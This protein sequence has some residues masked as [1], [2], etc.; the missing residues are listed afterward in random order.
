MQKIVADYNPSTGR[1]EMDSGWLVSK[2]ALSLAGLHYNAKSKLWTTPFNWVTARRIRS[3]FGE[4]LEVTERL[5]DKAS[6]DYAEWIY[7]SLQA[8]T[9][10]STDPKLPATLF[11]YQKRGGSFLL[12]AKRAVLADA[13]RVGKCGSVI[14]AAELGDLYPMIWIGPKST[15]ISAERQFKAHVPHRTTKQLDGT[16][17]K[18]RK[19]LEK[20]VDVLFMSYEVAVSHSRLASYGSVRMKRCPDCGGVAGGDDEITAAKCQ[21]HSK[22]LNAIHFRLTVVDEAHNLADPKSIRTRGCWAI[23]D[24]TEYAFGLTGTPLTNHIGTYWSILRLVAQH[25]WPSKTR[26]IDN[27][28][29]TSVSPWGGMEIHGLNPHTIEEFYGLIEPRMW[30]RTYEDVHG[31]AD[32]PEPQQRFLELPTAVRKAYNQ[33]DDTWISEDEGYVTTPLECNTRLHQMAS[34]CLSYDQ[35]TGEWHITSPS[36]KVDELRLVAEE[37]GDEPFVVFTVHTDLAVLALAGLEAEGVSAVYMNA[38]MSAAERMKCIDDFQS[39]KVRA[40]IS[41]YSLASEGLDL[42]VADTIVRLQRPWSMVKDEQA[43][44]RTMNPMKGNKRPL[45]IDILTAD[46]VDEHVA[47]ALDRKVEN[48]EELVRDKTRLREA[49]TI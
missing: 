29:A 27:Y 26:Y 4:R 10:A 46:T 39:G 20:P 2:D 15:L 11:E 45:Y 44:L 37:L 25:E 23:A 6:K 18:R 3:L 9:D 49:I 14:A 8:R 28:V 35:T 19:E 22:E 38:S 34:G 17:A 47:I 41:T 13:P 5:A 32:Q 21:A 43:S 16:P 30:R 31:E 24:Q 40:F 7:P 36:W 33:L 1:I 42:S 48:L 12:A